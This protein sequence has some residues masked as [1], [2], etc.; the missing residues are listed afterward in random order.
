MQFGGDY[1]RFYDSFYSEK[2]Y[3]GEARFVLSRVAQRLPQ[4]SPMS[5]LDLGCGTGRH[6]IEFVRAG[7]RVHGIDLSAQMLEIARERFREAGPVFA[8][9]WAFDAGDIRDA[10]AGSGRFDTVFCLFHVLCYLRERSDIV[11]AFENARR[12]L[13]PGGAYL[14]DFWHGGAVFA[15]PPTVREKSITTPTTQVRRISE[16]VWDRANSRVEINYTIEIVDRASGE[17]DVQHER[18]AVRYLF[19]AEVG[20]WLATAG[21]EVVEMGEWLTAQPPTDASFSTYALARAV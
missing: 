5:I 4:A 16:P 19:P 6:D 3:P 11:A 14:F 8:G 7:H 10:E 20:E 9:R 13:K 12:H 21:F 2:D 17:I 1:S 15:D 18:H